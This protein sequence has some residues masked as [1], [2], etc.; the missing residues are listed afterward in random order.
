[1]ANVN[2]DVREVESKE[3]VNLLYLAS[4]QGEIC[5]PVTLLEQAEAKGIPVSTD[6]NVGG[7]KPS[8]NTTEPGYSHQPSL[9]DIKDKVEESTN[10]NQSSGSVSNTQ[11]DSSNKR[12]TESDVLMNR[13]DRASCERE[14]ATKRVCPRVNCPEKIIICIDVSHEMEKPTFRSRCGDKF[15]QIRLLKRALGIFL[16]TKHRLDKRHEF[17]LLILR[18]EAMWISDFTSDPNKVITILE[19]LNDTYQTESCDLDS[20]F[21]LVYRHV[22]LPVRTENL[23][24]EPPAYIVRVLLLFGRSHCKPSLTNTQSYKMLRASPYF[25]LDAYYIHETP[26]PENNC[27]EIFDRLCELDEDGLSYVLEVSRN[28]TRLYD[29]MAQLLSHPLQRPLQRDISHNIECT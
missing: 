5:D 17:A 3:C 4:T 6:I 22:R 28:P 7:D 13:K 23:S 26:S 16:H 2:D 19:D 20:L 8:H 9:R 29:C 1:M 21:D 25:F 14:N 12:C 11:V 10:A 24:S 18:D 15:A 27:E